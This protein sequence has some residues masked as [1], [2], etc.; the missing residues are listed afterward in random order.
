MFLVVVIQRGGTGSGAKLYPFY[1]NWKHKTLNSNYSHTSVKSKRRFQI[2][3]ADVPEQSTHTPHTLENTA[4]SASTCLFQIIYTYLLHILNAFNIS[5]KTKEIRK[6]HSS[7]TLKHQVPSA[8]ASVQR[9]SAT[10]QE[11]LTLS[12]HWRS[13]LWCVRSSLNNAP[14][15]HLHTP[16]PLLLEGFC[17]VGSVVDLPRPCRKTFSCW[18]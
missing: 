7:K 14:H 6:A 10:L 18:V 12:R 11:I 5:E 13:T 17:C 1:P 9:T 3:R 16:S 4:S 15:F 2:R 8:P